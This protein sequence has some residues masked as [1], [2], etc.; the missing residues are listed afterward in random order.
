PEPGPTRGPDPRAPAP[1]VPASAV[2]DPMCQEPE[3]SMRLSVPEA[4]HRFS[5][6]AA[7]GELGRRR[8]GPN[9]VLFDRDGTLV[10]NVPYNGDPSRVR[11]VPGARDALDALRDAEVRVGVVT[12]QSGLAAVR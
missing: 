2:P 1:A 6:T 10:H 4:T 8:H 9:A 5:W 11:A 12:N 7:A 3:V